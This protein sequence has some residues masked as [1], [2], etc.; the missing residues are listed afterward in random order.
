MSELWEGGHTQKP[1]GFMISGTASEDVSVG[2]EVR[3]LIPEPIASELLIW[4]GMG[5]G[6]EIE[7]NI[8]IGSRLPMIVSRSIVLEEGAGY[9][10]A[11]FIAPCALSKGVKRGWAIQFAPR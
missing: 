7:T 5:V 4:K 8:R 9:L 3:L 10:V 1:L 11:I 2:D 6:F